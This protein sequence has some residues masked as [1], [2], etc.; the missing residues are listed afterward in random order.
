VRAADGGGDRRAGH[1]RADAPRGAEEKEIAALKKVSDDI[2]ARWH[3]LKDDDPARAIA[4]FARRNQVTQIIIGSSR[5]SRW[6]QI[7]GGGSNVTRVL[8]EAA[9]LGIDVHVIALDK[10]PR[11]ALVTAR[12]AAAAEEDG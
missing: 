9:P 7:T 12:R 11:N 6:Q 8:R 4:E 2:G 10:P 1:G 3:D 5:R